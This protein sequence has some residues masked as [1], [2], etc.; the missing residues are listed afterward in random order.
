METARR[1]KSMAAPRSAIVAPSENWLVNRAALI[2]EAQ[3]N[4]PFSGV[5]WECAIWDVSDAYRHRTRGYNADRPVQRLLFTR[6]SFRPGEAGRAFEGPFGDVV[7]SLVCVRH[8]QRGQ[9]AMNHMVFVRAT[10]YVHEALADKGYE[11]GE[12][13][14]D[15]LDVAAAELFGRERESSAYKVVGYIEEFADMLDRNGLCRQRLD[16]RYRRKIRPRFL[17]DGR[18][19]IDG[20]SIAVRSRLPDEQAIQAIGALYRCVPRGAPPTDPTSADRILVLIATLM[21]CTGLR[22]GEALTLPERPVS[23]AKDGS[24]TLRYA[25]LKGRAD[26]V[27]VDWTHKPLLTETEKLVEEV[28]EELHSA[29]QAARCVARRYH[30]TGELLANGSC[31]SEFDS[32][33]LPSVLG[34]RSRN[35]AQFLQTRHIPYRRVGGLIRVHRADLLKGL[36]RDH[37]TKPAI[38]GAAG[39]GLALHEAL[40]VVYTNQMHRGRK[41]TL[42]YAAR[43]ITYQNVS[44]FLSG[45]SGC[46][47]IFERH[48]M[49]NSDGTCIDIRSHGF[50][51]FLNHLLDEGGTPELVQTKWFG[52]KHTADTKAYHHL[53]PVEQAAQVRKE[54]F[55]G[56]MK[57]AVV[58][59]ARA[60]PAD[61]AQMFVL[62]RVHAVHDVGTGMCLH[63]FQMSPCPHHL[64][65]TVDCDDYVWRE[66]DVERADELKRQAAVVR[67][68]LETA[69]KRAKEGLVAPDW[70]THLQSRYEQLMG[71][72]TTLGFTEADLVRYIEGGSNG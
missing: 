51:H 5:A 42:T 36:T 25:R 33:V 8:R 39:S 17:S 9:S 61:R 70:F 7:K 29:T 10:R 71:Q 46:A 72:L 16:W 12:L 4:M 30:E 59:T 68:S 58:D 15:N 21:T 64:R 3:K 24:K 63:D 43:P 57:G 6:H 49:V 65:C 44:D 48:Q 34:L 27:T 37:W 66:A 14:A 18:K 28:L 19:P 69:G 54:I 38:W 11:I 22:V 50:R 20:E 35:V 32:A 53:T 62:A 1:R 60:L 47:S 40:C 2:A 41:T 56:H 23:V 52:R 26:D 55:G 67:I 45:R 13:S 31:A